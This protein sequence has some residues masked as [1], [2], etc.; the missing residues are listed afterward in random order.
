MRHPSY[1]H[2]TFKRTVE[3]DLPIQIIDYVCVDKGLSL[4]CE[5]NERIRSIFLEA[6]D[7]IYSELGLPLQCGRR[8]VLADLGVP[9]SSGKPRVHP[10]LGEYGPWD[11]FDYEN[12]SIHISYDPRS[13]KI[14][15]LTLMRS[16]VV[17]REEC[18]GVP[19]T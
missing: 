7:L 17:P 1:E 3:N 13:D 6:A 10:I 2:L 9:S 4:A 16:D 18:K 15:I 5:S 19:S 8:V 14:R 11:R 12:H